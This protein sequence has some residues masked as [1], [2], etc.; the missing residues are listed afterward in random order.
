MNGTKTFDI[1]GDLP[2]GTTVLE[3]SAGTGKTFTIAALA[4][5]YVAEGHAELR[6]LML[7]TFGR[8]ATQELRERVRERLVSAERGLADPAHARTAAHDDL[9]RLL[10]DADDD[11][12]A[13]RRKRLATALADFDAA[14]LTT[15][16]GFCQQMLRG[17]GVAGDHEPDAVFVESLDDLVVEVTGD[18][19]LRKFG[20]PDSSDPRL[21]YGEALA[22][23]RSAV[24]DG[25]AA[26]A[27]SDADP[28]STAGQC[29]GIAV[30]ARR[31]VEARK[32][33]RRL[34]A[35]DDLLTRLCAAL[36]DPGRG[37]DAR[38]R[39][40]SR[41][42][43]VMVDEFQ[44]TDPVQWR[45]LQLAF[46]GHTTLVLIGDPKQAIYAFRG[47]DVVAYLAATERATTQATLARN[48]R[49]DEALLT[50]LEA[51]FGQ[52]AL[53]DPRIIVRPVDSAHPGRRL[54]GAP[55]G[56]PLRLRVVRRDDT[57]TASHKVPTVGPTRD[58][59]AADLAA[60][61]ARLLSS[62]ALLAGDDGASDPVLPGD[63]AVLDA[64]QQ[65]GAVGA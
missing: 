10:A 60:D 19:Y 54:S 46:D 41:Y 17:L 37:H 30:A 31:E 9:L 57:G 18:L 35:Y 33:Q 25:Q 12:V 16:H 8:L 47:G 56:T 44:D 52:A 32:R 51:V 50:G 43:V 26:L 15:T 2:E 27:P 11:E 34:I 65:A 6:E 62:G 42:K 21:T 23:V 45:I 3:A 13:L 64:H 63:V 28:D 38:Q 36:D 7:V 48:Q 53:G 14:T 49:S 20:R 29:H 61:V 4:T 1:C 5:R 59:I 55:V 24:E 58:L 40:R 22:T 39:V